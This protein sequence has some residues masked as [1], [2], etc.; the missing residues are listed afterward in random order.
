[1]KSLLFSR[2]W[3][4]TLTA[5]ACL[6]GNYLLYIWGLDHI[7]PG[8]AQILIQLAPLLLLIGSVVIFKERFSAM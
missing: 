3:P 8:A 1:M 2:S 4:L 7:T 5:V 6:L